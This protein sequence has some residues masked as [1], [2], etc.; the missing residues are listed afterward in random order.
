MTK[1]ISFAAHCLLV[2]L[3]H[4]IRF[5]HAENRTQVARPEF[6]GSGGLLLMYRVA[7]MISIRAYHGH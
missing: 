1:T 7:Y 4:Q 3:L 6:L 5:Q 2:Q